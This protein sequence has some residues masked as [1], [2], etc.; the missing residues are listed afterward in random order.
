MFVHCVQLALC[1]RGPTESTKF[2][3]RSFSCTK[4]LLMDFAN[5]DKTDVYLYLVDNS[6]DETVTKI[7]EGTISIS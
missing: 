7:L 3:S 5:K 2:F 6:F 1:V 4:H